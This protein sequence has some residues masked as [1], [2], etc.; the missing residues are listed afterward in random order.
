MVFVNH[1]KKKYDSNLPIAVT[2]YVSF[3][4]DKDVIYVIS[5]SGSIHA[6]KTDL[7]EM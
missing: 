2:I 5:V 3:I 4:T 1:N 7:P 6:N